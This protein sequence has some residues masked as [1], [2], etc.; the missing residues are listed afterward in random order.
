VQ[1]SPGSDVLDIRLSSTNEEKLD[2]GHITTTLG[3]DMKN[4]L[5]QVILEIG[6]ST[7]LN[8][9]VTIIF[10]RNGHGVVQSSLELTI[11]EV[12][13]CPGSQQRFYDVI[14]PRI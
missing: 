13:L 2:K 4:S 14:I 11:R 5:L 1:R 3:S 9:S 10:V 6:I 12:D 7:T 8:E